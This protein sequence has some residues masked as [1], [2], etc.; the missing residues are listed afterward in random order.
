MQSDLSSGTLYK[1]CLSDGSRCATPSQI[2]KKPRFHCF[3]R[4]YYSTNRKPNKPATM[5]RSRRTSRSFKS[6]RREAREQAG[7]IRQPA[8]PSRLC[9]PRSGLN[10]NRGVSISG[11][12]DYKKMLGFAGVQT[13]CRDRPRLNRRVRAVGNIRRRT[14]PR[15]RSA[16]SQLMSRQQSNK[17]GLPVC[18]RSQRLQSALETRHR[19]NAL[20]FVSMS[21]SLTSCRRLSVRKSVPAVRIHLAPPTSLRFHST[22]APPSVRP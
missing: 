22:S 20:Q 18:G 17:K 2:G 14:S 19:D 15:A 10:S 21:Q 4:D 9:A 12:S 3:F 1:P 8:P 16:T 7:S 5:S 13:H 6:S 11:Q